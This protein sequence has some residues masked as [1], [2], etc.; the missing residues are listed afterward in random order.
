MY[1]QIK[2]IKY[3][4]K[5]KSSQNVSK[6]FFLILSFSISLFAQKNFIEDEFNKKTTLWE[7]YV[8]FEVIGLAKGNPFDEIAVVEFKN[9]ST[10]TVIKTEMFYNLKNKWNFR[11]TGVEVGLW[12]FNSFS[13]NSTLNGIAGSVLVEPN[14]NIHAKGFVTNNK[15][16]W[17]TTDSIKNVYVPQFVMY[18]TPKYFYQDEAQIDKDIQ[19]FL[20]K[21][22][23][24]GFHIPGSAYWFNIES[25]SSNEVIDIY[26]DNPNPDIRVFEAYE[27]L[28]SKVHKIGKKVHIWL[29]GDE[30]DHWTPKN[31]KG[32]LNGQADKRLLRYICARLGPIP[33]WTM[34]YGFDNWRWTTTADVNKWRK[35]MHGHL[36]SNYSHLLGVRGGGN[37]DRDKNGKAQPSYEEQL[38]QLSEEMDYSSYEQHKP[39]YKAYLETINKRP[40]KPSFSEDRFRIRNKLAK[41]YSMEEVRRGL[42]HS[43]MAGGVANIWGV[44]L[45]KAPDTKR[46]RSEYKSEVFPNPEWIKTY[47]DVFNMRFRTDLIVD[48]SF[49]NGYGL[50][51][52]NN[53]NFIIYKE[54]TD[55]INFNLQKISEPLPVVA[56]D[57]KKY[58]NEISFGFLSKNIYKWHAPYKSDWIIAIGKFDTTK[59][60]LPRDSLVVLD[61]LSNF[62]SV[63]ILS[64]SAKKYFDNIKVTLITQEEKN[65]NNFE[66][67]RREANSHKWEMIKSFSATNNSMNLSTYTF[68][69]SAANFRNVYFYKIEAIFSNGRVVISDS[70]K[71]T[72]QDTSRNNRIKIH[73]FTVKQDFSKIKINLVTAFEENIHKIEIQKS[74]TKKNSW[75]SI[76]NFLPKNLNSNLIAYNYSDKIEDNKKQ[77]VYRA[78]IIYKDG[79]YEFTKN[80]NVATLP[81]KFLLLQNYPNPFNN[82]TVIEFSLP[83]REKIKLLIYNSLGQLVSVIFNKVFDKGYHNIEFNAEELSSGVYFYILRSENHIEKRKML[84]LK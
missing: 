40:S 62:N 43:T 31:L 13:T 44:Q 52:L 78:K 36:D 4:T 11:F 35:F 42:Y 26:G 12:T 63:Q 3:D 1:N 18:S 25:I 39:S 51:N 73:S 22:G 55:Q 28:L 29:W 33:G 30:S 45:K 64:F 17:T 41:D 66:F 76:T 79:N 49:T 20:I 5:E 7:P 72:H 80:E 32:G 10:S 75:T 83:K 70:I 53:S 23:F 2:I 9:E 68:V 24:D 16:L 15:N 65:I 37:S 34:E 27:L 21:H 60:I 38:N 46:D 19:T 74:E 77:Y 56:I 48:T 8:D 54:N 47:S 82:S 57:T 58:Y 6:I 14:K 84:Y 59:N 81:D 61:S 69:D 67:K 71:Y 50:K